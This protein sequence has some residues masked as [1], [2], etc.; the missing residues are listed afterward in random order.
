MS[1]TLVIHA[2]PYPRRSLVTQRLKAVFD[3]APHTEVRAL[4]DLYPDFD[5]DV[6]AEQQALSTAHLVVWLA[7]VYWYSVPSLMKHWFDRVLSHGWAYGEG[8][9]ALR[10]K[11]AWWVASVGAAATAYA[12]GAEH[13]RPFADFVA[14]I[15]QTARYCG[16]QWLPPY[17]VHAGHTIT[18]GDRQASCD[19]LAQSLAQHQAALPLQGATA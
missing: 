10:G 19:A 16:M 15:E 8:G 5:I 7:P 3:A 12:P 18:E 13:G 14:P 17:L 9:Q 4:Y 1:H 6:A 11:T 2:H